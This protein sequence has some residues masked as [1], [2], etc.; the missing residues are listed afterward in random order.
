MKTLTEISGTLVRTAAAAIAEARR[1]MPHEETPVT[2]A[3][4]VGEAPS[5]GAEPAV[6]APAEPAAKLDPDAESEAV[7]AL[8][9]AAVAKATGC[10]GDRLEMVRAAVKAAGRRAGDVRLVRVFGVEEPLRGAHV[11]GERQYVV[12]LLP[13][14]MQQVADAHRKEKGRGGGK[15]GGRGGGG[16]RGSKGSTSGG[17]SMDSVKDDR[18]GAR[19]GGKPGGTPPRK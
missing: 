13:S 1:S 11:I 19:G 2:P 12:D 14:S 16:D 4:V 7:K 17:F 8:L 9:D 5:E 3:V 6:A 15:G 10:S 18:K